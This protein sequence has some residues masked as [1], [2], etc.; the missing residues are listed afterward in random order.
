MSKDS[1]FTGQQ[2]YATVKQVFL[3]GVKRC[4]TK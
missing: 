2:Y 4:W 3:V 1:H